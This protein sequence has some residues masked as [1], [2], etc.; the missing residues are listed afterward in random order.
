MTLSNSLK[1][2]INTLAL[3]ASGRDAYEVLYDFNLVSS[4]I[5]PEMQRYFAQMLFK[6]YINSG[7]I[8][9]IGIEQY[10]FNKFEW[11]AEQRKY[12]MNNFLDRSKYNYG[13]MQWCEK[14]QRCVPRDLW[15]AERCRPGVVDDHAIIP[16]QHAT[17]PKQEGMSTG[18]KVA[19][20]V[21]GASVGLGLLYLLLKPRKK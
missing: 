2:S 1:Q 19:I 6:A 13:T 3:E 16:N 12:N 11:V 20:G 8:S 14:E 9:H 10:M 21:A 4:E 15:T 7:F 18:G 5:T 17:I